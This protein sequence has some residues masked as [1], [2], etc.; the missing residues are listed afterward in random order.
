MYK[1]KFKD[2]NLSKNL[3]KKKALFMLNKHEQRKRQL[4]EGKD[5]IFVYGEQLWTIDRVLK[6]VKKAKIAEDE[7]AAIG[8]LLFMVALFR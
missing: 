3:S 7:T 5:T 4:P 8:M 2:W 6:T 1:D